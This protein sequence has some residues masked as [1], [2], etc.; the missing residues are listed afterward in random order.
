MD[1]Q[2]IEWVG[3]IAPF[4]MGWQEKSKVRMQHLKNSS[5]YAPDLNPDSA[6]AD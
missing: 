5:D 6:V 3:D 2:V 1:F 4:E